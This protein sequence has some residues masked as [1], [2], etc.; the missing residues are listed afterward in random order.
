MSKYESSPIEIAVK[1]HLEDCFDHTP[2]L[3]CGVSGGVDS[4][5]LLHVL[6]RL[7]IDL[8]IVHI[9]YQTR[10]EDSEKDQDLVEK[11]CLLYQ[12]E[13]V[14]VRLDPQA[15]E[16]NFQ[17]WAREQ[18]YEIFR[19]LMREESAS[20]IATAHHQTDQVETILQRI[21]R[22]AGMEHWTG[23]RTF[24]QG[25][26]RPLLTL[27]KQEIRS[28][29]LQEGLLF[30][31]DSSNERPEYSRN[32]IRLGLEP[33]LTRFFPGWQKNLL[34]LRERADEVEAMQMCILA[35]VLDADK[36]SVNRQLL[37]QLPKNLWPPVLSRWVQ[38]RTSATRRK[39]TT[40]QFLH[41]DSLQTGQAIA[42][43]VDAGGT[44]VWVVRDRDRFTLSKSWK[45]EK[46][47]KGVLRGAGD[48]VGDTKA[49]DFKGDD[50]KAA[51]VGVTSVGATGV[52]ATNVKTTVDKTTVD[53][54]TVGKPANRK[55][56]VAACI[57][58]LEMLR[59]GVVPECAERSGVMISLK[60]W[61]TGLGFKNEQLHLDAAK[62]GFPL[63]LRRWRDGDR[64]QPLGMHGTRL[65]SD[66]LTDRK[67][68]SAEKKRAQVLLSF[69]GTV[70]AVIFPHTLSDGSAGS[71][72][73]NCKC[74]GTTTTIVTL[75][76]S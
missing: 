46:G 63:T 73:E 44:V 50:F 39:G 59:D 76:I 67:V 15:S 42:G 25:L 19:G 9:N 40:R 56:E 17:A 28:Y 57:I 60:N 66:L 27:T 53:K 13:C 16:G 69:D 31:E 2:R 21:F 23:M 32:F 7:G 24:E 33:E 62:I 65:V 48:M 45:G 22:G 3:V 34:A 71:I 41:I 52:E 14:S 30:R 29:A 70:C 8:L 36:E 47:E 11:M 1:K 43:G 20:G 64:I 61:H 5:V 18:R 74:T 75:S 37:L 10:G 38:S 68:S 4:M 12:A 35:S 6:R 54:T 58:H 51:D 55:L 26:F 72:A 49:G